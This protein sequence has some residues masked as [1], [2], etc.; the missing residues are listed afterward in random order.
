MTSTNITTEAP[1]GYLEAQFEKPYPLY[2]QRVLHY[3]EPIHSVKISTTSSI[4]LW[5]SFAMH[6][7]L[8]GDYA[9]SRSIEEVPSRLIC[10]LAEL[11]LIFNARDR[12]MKMRCS[13]PVDTYRLGHERGT[14]CHGSEV[15]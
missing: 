9:L 14:C 15:G 8:K 13:F 11:K 10:L 3:F 7:F 4:V 5:Q 1:P 12:D 6:P 2:E